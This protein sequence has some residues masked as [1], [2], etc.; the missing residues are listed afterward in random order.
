MTD[1]LH[2]GRITTC[3]ANYRLIIVPFCLSK[4]VFVS[5]E[6]VLLHKSSQY[7]KHCG[8]F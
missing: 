4:E 7:T 1:D 6:N 5:F 2:M 3:I 8:V